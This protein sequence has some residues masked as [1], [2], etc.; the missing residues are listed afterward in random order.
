ME[1]DDDI[2]R[3]LGDDDFDDETFRGGDWTG[4]DL[5]GKTFFDCELLNLSA[6]EV[7]LRD[8]VFE[9]CRFEGCDLTM[10]VIVGARFSDVEFVDCKLMGVDWSQVTGLTFSVS[11][12]RCVLS[13][14][15]FMDLRMKNI[16]IIGCR[17]HETNFA[18]VDLTGADF[19]DTDLLGAKFVDTNLSGADL[20]SASN[21]EINPGDNTLRKTRYSIEAALAMAERMGIVVSDS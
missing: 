20:S 5:S 8:C 18:G 15:S 6:R 14:G 7:N 19:A 17:A 3:L 4:A 16:K 21:Y 9:D 13:H 12:Q 2:Q 11:Y 10:A 1:P